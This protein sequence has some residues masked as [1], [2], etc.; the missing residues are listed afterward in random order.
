MSSLL[1]QHFLTCYLNR[2]HIDMQ[3]EEISITVKICG[4]MW[5]IVQ[6]KSK[7]KNECHSFCF[8]ENR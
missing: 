1:Y 8:Q 7:I 4:Y 5:K 3:G 2:K 6:V